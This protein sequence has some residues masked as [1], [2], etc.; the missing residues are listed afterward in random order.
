MLCFRQR[1]RRWRKRR[2]K[3]GWQNE[4]TLW[5][6]HCWRDH[7]SQMLPRIAARATFV[8]WTQKMFLKIFRNIS[9]VRAARNN[10]ASFCHGR[11]TSQGTML[12]P[13]CVL[14][15]PRPKFHNV[16]FEEKTVCNRGQ[17]CYELHVAELK[18]YPV[19]RGFASAVCQL[20]ARYDDNKYFNFIEEWGTVRSSKDENHRSNIAKS[21]T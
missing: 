11:A 5:R 13:Q 2:L 10:V 12:L 8:S 18:G 4:D 3:R 21:F 6:Q 15:L 1:S 19:A 7:V 20:P 16:F 17:A 14:V 9:C